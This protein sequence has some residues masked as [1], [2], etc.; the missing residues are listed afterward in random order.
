LQ[1]EKSEPISATEF[2]GSGLM[3]DGL[4]TVNHVVTSRQDRRA[5]SPKTSDTI[6][7]NKNKNNKNKQPSPG[8]N[9]F[10]AQ[11]NQAVLLD[12]SSKQKNQKTNKNYKKSPQNK[13]Q[14]L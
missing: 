7:K 4:N 13:K 6:I 10:P 2:S 3:I 12:N 11:D 5:T 9:N 1:K 14:F 8:K